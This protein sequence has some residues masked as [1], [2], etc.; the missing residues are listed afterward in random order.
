MYKRRSFTLIELL[1]ACHPKRIARRTIQPI[2]TLIE[3]LVVIAIIAI[4]ASMLLPALNKARETAMKITCTNNQN[5]ISKGFLMYTVDN[6]DM[7]PLGYETWNGNTPDQGKKSWFGNT[8]KTG[9][10]T[11]YL[12][13]GQISYLSGVKPNGQVDRLACPNRHWGDTWRGSPLI[14]STTPPGEHS[15]MD[16]L[17]YGY[18]RRFADPVNFI[19]VNERKVTRFH[20][21]SG[22]YLVGDSVGSFLNLQY[23]YPS[24]SYVPILRHRS[25][26]VMTFC[27]GHT[28][29][30]LAGEIVTDSGDI[31]WKAAQ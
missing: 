4:L 31:A 25:T 19:N 9:Y 16:G 1:V 21:P 28:A 17:S 24:R 6:S 15:S 20:Q 13:T 27:D 2:F 18:N 7:L 8:I 30:L 12:G 23:M 3:L 29:T 11:P 5:M 10:L 26:C 22:S 14:L